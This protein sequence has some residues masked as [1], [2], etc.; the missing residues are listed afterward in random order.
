MRP[1]TETD[2]TGSPAAR[3]ELPPQAA[4]IAA[5]L[6]GFRREMLRFATLQLRDQA[7][8]EDAVQE[9]MLAALQ[10][11]DRFGERAR[12]K[13]W[14][15]SILRNKIVDIIR[16]RVREPAYEDP[17]NEIDEADFDPLFQGN[18]HWQR[19]TR[20]SDWGNPERSFENRSFW[21]V[22]D[23]CMNRLPPG[24]ARVFMMREML[25]LETDEI[26]A[27]LSMSSNN[28][29]VVLHRAR[30][31]LRLCLDQRWFAGSGGQAA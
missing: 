2:P 28:C 12:L 11:A 1:S 8:A 4:G 6:G 21:A 3:R 14:V 22:F 9:A 18:G 30:M 23:A 5:E 19:D 13:T 20:P 17:L 15:F 24:T 16:R 10:G 29:W 7:S 25:G 27:E 31:G 26:C